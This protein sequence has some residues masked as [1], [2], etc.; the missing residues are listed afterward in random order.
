MIDWQTIA[1]VLIILAA[2][3]YVG[4]HALMRLRSFRA[5]GKGVDS[6]CATGCG[7]C[8]ANESKPAAPANA[9]VQ[10]RRAGR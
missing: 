4:R 8:G 1:V 3:L 2:C 5:G 6:S 7:G 10:I 9:L